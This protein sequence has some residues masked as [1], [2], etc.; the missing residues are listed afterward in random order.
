MN[1]W[2]LYLAVGVGS[3]LGSVCRLLVG[4]LFMAFETAS[5]PWATLLVNVLGSWLIARF[6]V[7]ASLRECGRLARLQPFLVAGFCGGFT[8]FSLFSLEAVTFVADG[9]PLLAAW[10]VVISVP[11]WLIAAWWGDRGARRALT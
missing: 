1:T 11:A 4:W 7:H 9:R 10:Y 2:R 8:T 3:A 5:F 6:A